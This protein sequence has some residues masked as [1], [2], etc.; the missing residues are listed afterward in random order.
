MKRVQLKT[1]WICLAIASVLSMGCQSRYPASHY[2]ASEG[3]VARVG[4]DAISAFRNLCDRS[5]HTSSLA[6]NLSPRVAERYGSLIWMPQSFSSH[7]SKTT[8]WIEDWLKRG[9]KTLVYVGRDY[10]PFEDYWI[11]VSENA[12]IYKPAVSVLR[13]RE[14]VAMAAADLE[15]LRGN[16]R[17]KLVYPWGL[18]DCSLSEWS[19][20]ES[21]RGEWSDT[22]QSNSSR[23][24]L[25]GYFKDFASLDL[26]SLTEELDWEA[27]ARVE[28][29]NS[30]IGF[31][32]NSTTSKTWTDQDAQQLARVR[33]ASAGNP[34]RAEVVLA[35]DAG[36]P[37][38]TILVNDQWPNSKIILVANAS[39]VS[40]YS[41]TYAGNRDLAKRLILELAPGRVGFI[42]T[43]EDP[44]LLDSSELAAQRGFEMFTVWPLSVITLHAAFLGMLVLVALFPIFGR[45]RQLPEVSTQNFGQHVEA[46]GALLL[47][48]RDRFYAL[49]T[50]ADY[51]RNVRKDSNSPWA[52]CDKGVNS[53]V[54]S[55]FSSPTEEPTATANATLTP[56]NTTRP[57]SV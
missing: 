35:T 54:G 26:D 18:Y 12:A 22:I 39:L 55:P 36:K 2:G 57:E 37:L 25:R 4:P 7:E 38:V 11:Y 27:S 6:P 53:D 30:K 16:A 46:M 43:V 34:F 20:I 45:P 24:R 10:S 8:R 41:L 3:T 5:S 13:A 50:I 21:F 42:S 31:L 52:Q 15:K 49:A 40:N 14:N 9:G 32:G 56:S 1:V 47:K 28:T 51:F 48:S 23:I 17:E 19:T 44:K 33:A 29:N